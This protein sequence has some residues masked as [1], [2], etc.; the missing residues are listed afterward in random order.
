MA[1]ASTAGEVTVR[2]ESAQTKP[3]V[4]TIDPE[5]TVPVGGRVVD[6]AGNPV[7]GASIQLWHRVPGTTGREEVVEPIMFGD[8][9]RSLRTD[10][11]G[12]YRAPRRLPLGGECYARAVAPGRLAAFSGAVKLTGESHELPA[13]CCAGADDRRTDGRPA[14]QAGGR[15]R[16]TA[17]R[18]WPDADP[19]DCAQT[20]AFNLPAFW[21]GRP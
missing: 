5:N 4:L 8:A 12:R 6:L 19:G 20:D 15:G 3:I 18:R 16:G 1:L 11:Q 21:K 14:G 9:I 13:I 7:A 17:I 10:S 2:A